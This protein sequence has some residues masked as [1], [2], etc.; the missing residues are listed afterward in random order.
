[1]LSGLSRPMMGMFVAPIWI[2]FSRT[3]DRFG[4]G[5]RTAARDA[6]LSD[7][8]TPETKG[9]VFGFHRAMDTLGAVIGP[10]LALL[11]LY[12]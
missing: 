3:L 10:L 4:K 8:A 12:F 2:F 5:I 7:E 9:N 1:M 6:I 11:Y